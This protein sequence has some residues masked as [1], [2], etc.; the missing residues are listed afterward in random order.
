MIW[1]RSAVLRFYSVCG[2]LL[3]VSESLG[4]SYRASEN[5]SSGSAVCIAI[6]SP[7]GRCVVR[8]VIHLGRE[9]RLSG[10]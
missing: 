2:L 7:G 9:R 10:M 3:Q 5:S 8:R 4:A 6:T 1:K